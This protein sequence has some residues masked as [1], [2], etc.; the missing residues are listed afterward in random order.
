MWYCQTQ[1]LLFILTSGSIGTR[2]CTDSDQF[3]L[4]PALHEEYC[5]TG[6]RNACDYDAVQNPAYVLTITYVNNQLMEHS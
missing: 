5:T 1:R 2:A 6:A 4:P 3:T